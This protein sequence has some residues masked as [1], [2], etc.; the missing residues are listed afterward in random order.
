MGVKPQILSAYSFHDPKLIEIAGDLAENAIFSLPTY[1][2]DSPEPAISAF[3]DEYREKY[4][5]KPDQFAAHAYD[6]M[7]ILG[8]AIESGPTTGA[9]IN[10]YIHG[11]K[12]YPGVTGTITFSQDNGDV[13][14]PLRIFAVENGEFVPY[15]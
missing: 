3:V 6:C 8:K 7:M 15:K 13:K 9:E 4:G 2:P 1:D 5:K 10:G 11:L 14:K 12:N